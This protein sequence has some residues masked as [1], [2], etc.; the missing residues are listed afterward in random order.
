MATRTA[1]GGERHESSH[2]RRSST[3][4]GYSDRPNREQNVIQPLGLPNRAVRC[5]EWVPRA[6]E[7]WIVSETLAARAAKEAGR[8]ETHWKRREPRSVTMQACF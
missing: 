7:F 1:Q 5:P 8:R 3:L 6:T 2:R 4:A